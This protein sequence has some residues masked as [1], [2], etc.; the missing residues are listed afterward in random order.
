MNRPHVE[1]KH[2]TIIRLWQAQAAK[3]LPPHARMAQ[4]IQARASRKIA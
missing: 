4:A 3:H 2:K 1:L